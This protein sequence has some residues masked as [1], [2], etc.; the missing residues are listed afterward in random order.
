MRVGGRLVSLDSKQRLVS[1]PPDGCGCES[2]VA[3]AG[4]SRWINPAEECRGWTQAAEY[5]IRG[6]ICNFEHVELCGMDILEGLES[7]LVMNVRFWVTVVKGAYLRLHLESHSHFSRP[8]FQCKLNYAT[9]NCKISKQ[10]IECSSSNYRLQLHFLSCL[11]G[12]V[13]H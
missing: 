1:L 10:K 12:S 13:G 8:L 2:L 5:L 9:G 4:E 7:A 6:K 3:E 11:L